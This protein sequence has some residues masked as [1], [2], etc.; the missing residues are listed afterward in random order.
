M[1]KVLFVTFAILF[2]IVGC[3]EI[4]QRKIRE[5]YC[6]VIKVRHYRVGEKHTLQTTPEYQAIT[7]CG[8]TYTLHK[9]VSVGDTLLI[10][11]IFYKD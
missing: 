9:L 6:V 3:Q 11:T 2:L 7:D 5:S 10:K 1:K 4:T 8:T